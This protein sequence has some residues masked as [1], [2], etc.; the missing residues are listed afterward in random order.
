[1]ISLVILLL[2]RGHCSNSHHLDLLDADFLNVTDV[3]DVTN[4]TDVLDVSD[5]LD[6]PDV[7]DY[8]VSPQLPPH[9]AS[10]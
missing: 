7:P 1:L 4:V 2:P 8:P 3:S 10:Y 9:V 5:V 6:V